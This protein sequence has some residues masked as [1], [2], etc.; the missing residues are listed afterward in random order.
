[1]LGIRVS[2]PV[3]PEQETRLAVTIFHRNDL[4]EFVRRRIRY[5]DR[6]SV[7]DLRRHYPELRDKPLVD[8][9]II[10][11]QSRADAN[12]ND[13]VGVGDNGAGRHCDHWIEVT[14]SQ[15]VAEIS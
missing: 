15:R 9:D 8:V 5:L 12:G 3:L 4:G 2:H 14:G 7:A 13:V 1:M 10:D 6:M 11:Q